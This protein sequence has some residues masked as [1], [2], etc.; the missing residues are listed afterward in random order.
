[1]NHVFMDGADPIVITDLA[2]RI[3]DLNH[4]TVRVFGWTRE[5]ALRRTIEHF[6]VGLQGAPTDR[7]LYRIQHGETVR[8]LEALAKA[9]SG[10]SVPSL[11][12]AF[13]L[14]DE[15]DQAVGF[16][17][18]IKDITSLKQTTWQLE[19]KNR[20][21][22]Q[23]ANALSHDLGAPLNSIRGY[24][25]LLRR[26]YHGQL[27]EE[28]TEGLDFIVAGVDR[29][30]R[31]IGDLLDFTRME[32]GPS[33]FREVDCGKVLAQAVANL[34]A[35][36]K[37]NGAEVTSDPLPIVQGHEMQLVQL[38]QNL[39]GNAIKF[40]R[41]EPPQVRVS[42]EETCDGWQFAVRDNGIGIDSK[43]FDI[44]FDVFRR[45]H[46]DDVFPG[47][48]IGLAVCRSIVERHGGRIWVESTKGQGSTFF[49]TIGDPLLA[50][51][52][53]DIRSREGSPAP[54]QFRSYQN[55]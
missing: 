34:D 17:L 51:P 40:R 21:L 4:E 46:A 13:A 22:R 54:A 2:G 24:A 38:F 18:I 41:D 1:M 15:D 55:D 3:V 42:C 45:L 20:E 10:Q 23:F 30:T 27:D 31:M 8:N 53:D 5:E 9:K 48:G 7:L 11:V 32:C 37:E 39:I 33:C 49:F 44:V 47:T 26:R 6:A 19:Q 25:E 16:A 12:T 43:H 28:S 29:M 50:S 35:L 14:T 52:H 36:I